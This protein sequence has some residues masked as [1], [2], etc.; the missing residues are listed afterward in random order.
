M[1]PN[2]RFARGSALLFALWTAIGAGA[3]PAG[4]PPREWLDAATGHRVVRLSTQ[5]G[6]RSIYFHQNS[7]TPDGRFVLVEMAD[8][9]G[10]IEIATRRNIRLVEGKVRALFVGRKTGLVYFSRGENAGR[11]EQ[12]KSVGIYTVKPTGGSPK[13]VAVI[14]H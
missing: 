12:Q 5:P 7:V 13:L 9:L 10:V 14:P 2:K 11:P 6:T 1:R 3:A 4:E 8:G